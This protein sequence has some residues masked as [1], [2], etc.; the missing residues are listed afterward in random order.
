[1]NEW[2]ALVMMAATT[3]ADLIAL[4]ASDPE[5]VARAFVAKTLN[6]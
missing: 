6:R 4:D 3:A 5:T 2:D 1:M